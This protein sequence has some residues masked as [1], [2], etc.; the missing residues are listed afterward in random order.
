MGRKKRVTED[1][2]LPG[3]KFYYGAS[4]AKLIAHFYQEILGGTCDYIHVRDAFVSME[5]IQ[6]IRNSSEA[7]KPITMEVFQ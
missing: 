6:L 3:S 4:H 1:T 7:K 2:K 5:M